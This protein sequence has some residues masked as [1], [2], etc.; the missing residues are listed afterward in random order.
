M[1]NQDFYAKPVFDKFDFGFW[2][3]LKKITIDRHTY[4]MF[5]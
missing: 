2:C 4:E 1:K 5:T 3:N